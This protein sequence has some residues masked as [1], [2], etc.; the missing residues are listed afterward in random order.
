MIWILNGLSLLMMV[1][2]V[3]ETINYD[4]SMKTMN[5]KVNNMRMDCKQMNQQV[6]NM[7]E[8]IR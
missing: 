2:V 6:D 1:I 3:A 7:L 5:S 8:V 4:Q